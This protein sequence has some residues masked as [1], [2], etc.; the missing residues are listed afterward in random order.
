MVGDGDTLEDV[1]DNIKSAIAFHIETFG[2]E[3]LEEVAE[4]EDIYGE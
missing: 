4:P 3:V 2:R 1:L